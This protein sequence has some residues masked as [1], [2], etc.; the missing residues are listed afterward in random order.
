MKQSMKQASVKNI[1]AATHKWK[2]GVQEQR[3]GNPGAPVPPLLQPCWLPGT[4]VKQEAIILSK[5]TQEQETKH[6]MFSLTKTA[7]ADSSTRWAVPVPTQQSTPD[8]FTT[9][10]SKAGATE[11][12]SNAQQSGF[13][14]F[15]LVSIVF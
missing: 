3:S 4:W 2:Q 7:V 11:L 10:V 14:Q 15:V 12:S 6:H 9:T 8:L 5:L 13:L 1:S